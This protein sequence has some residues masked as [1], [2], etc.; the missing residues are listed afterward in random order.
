M[1]GLTGLYTTLKRKLRRGSG[2]ALQVMEQLE[3]HCL[4][5][6]FTPFWL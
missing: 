2:T 3:S 5:S 6:E 4:H 1:Q